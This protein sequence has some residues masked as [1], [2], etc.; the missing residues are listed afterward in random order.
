MSDSD[1]KPFVPASESPG[2]SLAFGVSTTMPVV[3][4]LGL[5]MNLMPI[6]IIALLGVI[7]GVLM[8]IP[9]RQGLIV[10]EHGKP[11]YP[12]GIACADILIVGEQ[13][14][15]T[16]TVFL[17]FGIGALY[18]GFGIRGGILPGRVVIFGL[19]C[20]RSHYGCDHRRHC[21]RGIG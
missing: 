1:F 17:G 6:L 18:K 15:N 20:R 16:K 11:A 21:R 3:L 2:E 19:Y 5:D 7:L 10:K 12:E 13:G 8:M 9:L 4:L 14:A